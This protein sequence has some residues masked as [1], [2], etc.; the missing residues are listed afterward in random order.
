M[1]SQTVIDLATGTQHVFNT[2]DSD[3][4]DQHISSGTYRHAMPWGHCVAYNAALDRVF[5]T[6]GTYANFVAGHCWVNSILAINPD[7]STTVT[8]GGGYPVDSYTPSNWQAMINSDSDLGGGTD[9]IQVPAGVSSKYPHLAVMGSKDGNIRLFNLADL[10]GQGGPGNVGGA[11]ETIKAPVGGSMRSQGTTWTDPATGTV[12]V[13]LMG[14]SGISAMTLAVDGSGNPSLLAGWTLKNGWTTSG[15]MVNG[16]LFAAVGGGEH[17]GT[18]ATHYLQAINPTNGAVV[19]SAAIGQFHWTSPIV[20]NGVVYM[21]DGNSGGF[22]SGHGGNLHAWN[23]SGSTNPVVA[24]G[25][26]KIV[27]LNSGLVVDAKGGQTTNETVVEQYAYHGGSNQVW[28]VTGLGGGQYKIIGVQ[29]GRA[30]EVFGAGTA[31]GAAIDIYDYTGAANQIWT[32]TPTTGNNF[33]LTPANATGSCLDVKSSGLTN[34][35]TLEI[36]KSNS[37]NSQQW[38][39]QA[40]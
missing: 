36:W 18:T 6:T 35:V 40:P 30:L 37:G 12:W 31:N 27:N 32:F 39:F 20:A 10:S 26:Y 3:Q 17:S 8:N 11:L 1:G 24:N 2:V 34:S 33:R 14:D 5:F 4:A 16:V 13:Y 29:S 25:A 38:S 21:C 23:L 19:W 7:G 28:A 22:G 15:I 9:I